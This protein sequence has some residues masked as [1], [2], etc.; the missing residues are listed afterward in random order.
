M[1]KFHD[2]NSITSNVKQNY[3]HFII[4]STSLNKKMN[5]FDQT[6]WLFELLGPSIRLAFKASLH[7]YNV[8]V[9]NR[10]IEAV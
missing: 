1:L 3:Y 6:S 5:N 10:C 9:E 7:D 4:Y 8:W 2:V